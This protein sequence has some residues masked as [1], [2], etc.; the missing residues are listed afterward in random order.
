MYGGLAAGVDLSG[1]CVDQSPFPLRPIL[2]R[3]E[4]P[5]HI[6]VT[7][8]D[9]V[10]DFVLADQHPADFAVPE[11]GQALTESRLARDAL[12]AHDD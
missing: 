8:G 2:A 3:V 6:Q 1:T 9:L 12:D 5:Q 7:A 11:S 10:T 4:Y